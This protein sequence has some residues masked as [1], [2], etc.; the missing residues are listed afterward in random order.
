LQFLS[1]RVIEIS[2]ELAIF[3]KIGAQAQE[4]NTWSGPI[5]CSSL[6]RPPASELVDAP[7]QAT[8]STRTAVP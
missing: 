4:Y 1:G 3:K 7:V 5:Q 8:A 2:K 6:Q